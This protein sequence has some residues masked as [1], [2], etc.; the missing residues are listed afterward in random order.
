MGRWLIV[1]GLVL[2]I[3]GL[4]VQYAPVRWWQWFGRL[5]GDVRIEKNNVRIYFPWVSM[6]LISVVLSLILSLIKRIRF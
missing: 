4:I 3:L 5:P 6:L 2:L 1:L